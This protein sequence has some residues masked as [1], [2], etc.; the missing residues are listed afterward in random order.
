MI[1]VIKND[2][3]CYET[4]HIPKGESIVTYL[5]ENTRWQFRLQRVSSQ[6]FDRIKKAQEK[7]TLLDRYDACPIVGYSP[8]VMGDY[9]FRSCGGLKISSDEEDILGS[10]VIEE[11]K[12]I[13]T[14]EV[15]FYDER[16]SYVYS[17]R[18]FYTMVSMPEVLEPELSNRQ[19]LVYRGEEL[20]DFRPIFESISQNEMMDYAIYPEKGKEAYQ[21]IYRK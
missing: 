8:I 1:E 14:P 19:M 13:Y 18:D 6:E 3:I 15:K 2:V 7:E 17:R 12:V 21:K 9:G 5:R 11:D 10:F 4:I 20:G 16:D